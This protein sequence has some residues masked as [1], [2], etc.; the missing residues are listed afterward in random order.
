MSKFGK[1]LLESAR[2]AME[3]AAS[4]KLGRA[5]LR[6]RSRRR[7]CSASPNRTFPTAVLRAIW[8]TRCD[9]DWEQHRRSPDQTARVLLTVIEREPDAVERALRIDERAVPLNP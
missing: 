3:I 9:L 8:N 2:E 5:Q 1:E 6:A 7:E 4:R